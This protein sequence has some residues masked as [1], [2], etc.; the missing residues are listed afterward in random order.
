MPRRFSNITAL[1]VICFFT[2]TS[3]GLFSVAHA[4]Q[5]AVNKKG[6]AAEQQRQQKPE[7]AEERFSRL[8][9]DL[10]TA[11]ADPKEDVESKKQRLIAGKG[12]IETLDADIHKQFAATEKRLKD[13]K[14]PAEILER[15]NRFVKHYDDNLSELK[16]NLERLDKAK[17]QTEA[18]AV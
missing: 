13:A 16:G 8:T 14:L 11:L 5:D 9:E 3:G 10:T 15:H 2:W 7:G 6:K 17:D 4:A 1:V 18:E 12:E